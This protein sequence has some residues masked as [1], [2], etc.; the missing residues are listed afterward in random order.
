MKKRENRER[1]GPG[2]TNKKNNTAKRAID[3]TKS[4]LNVRKQG[5]AAVGRGGSDER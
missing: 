5:N 1:A 3:E 2:N 4:I